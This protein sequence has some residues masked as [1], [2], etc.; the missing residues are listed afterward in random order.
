MF[1]KIKRSRNL[2]PFVKKI[3]ADYKKIKK[4]LNW[5][6]EDMQAYSLGKIK[7]MVDYAYFNT[8]FYKAEFDKAGYIPGSISKLS[9][10]QFL[11]VLT[12]NKLRSAINDKTIFVKNEKFKNVLKTST[13]GSTGEP[14]TLYF[15]EECL[16]LRNMNIVRG[17]ESMKMNPFDRHLQIWRKKKLNAAQKLKLFLKLYKNISVVDILDASGSAINGDNLKNIV[18]EIIDFKPN[19]IEGYVSAIY[20]LAKYA[21]INNIKIRPKRIIC[22]AEY[23]PH[24]IWDELKEVFQCPV[25]NLY[26]GT[27]FSLVSLS[28]D[29]VSKKMVFMDDFYWAEVIDEN[30]M[31][32]KEDD[33]GRILLTDYNSYYMPLIRYEIGDMA[34][35]STGFSG[36]FR[37]CKEIYG[38]INDIFV[39]PNKKL[40]F[41]HNWHIYFRALPGLERFKVIQE[42]INEIDI[43]LLPYDKE[44]LS[45]EIDKLKETLKKSLSTDM[46]INIKIVDNL[47]LGPGEKFRAVESKVDWRKY[48]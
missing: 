30:G 7:E 11:P 36:P 3:D 10:L 18:K 2:F 38:R 23:L 28:V 20:V 27:E 22:A 41:S 24:T 32:T 12:K 37:T 16:I 26:G 39:L 47:P 44:I 29:D 46:V 43:S 31:A 19:T 35:V 17:Y 33:V 6:P 13:T 42:S 45:K 1:K 9:D 48:I 34:E 4:R 40:M 14:L 15:D 25:Y 8:E 5:S 21:K